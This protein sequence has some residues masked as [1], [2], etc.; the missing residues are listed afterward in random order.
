MLIDEKELSKLIE[1]KLKPYVGKKVTNNM[2]KKMIKD[3]R[4]IPELS[5]V[6]NGIALLLALESMREM[7]GDLNGD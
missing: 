4:S 3:I 6:E 5:E 2:R 7:F 1:A